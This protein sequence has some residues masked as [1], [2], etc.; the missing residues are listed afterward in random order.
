MAG[1]QGAH[2]RTPPPDE[3]RCTAL[4]VRGERCG[5]YR[6]RDLELC[7]RHSGIAD[8]AR[9]EQNALKSAE[10][11]MAERARENYLRDL[12]AIEDRQKDLL[13]PPARTPE[14]EA[15]RQV[16]ARK[17]LGPNHMPNRRLGWMQDADGFYFK[18]VVISQDELE[19]RDR[20]MRQTVDVDA[21]ERRDEEIRERDRQARAAW[22]RR[23]PEYARAR[24]FWGNPDVGVPPMPG[25]SSA[26]PS[27]EE[28]PWLY[29]PRVSKPTSY[30][31]TP[32]ADQTLWGV[33]IGPHLD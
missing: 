32:L 5:S 33:Q 13:T 24:I 31:P 29:D 8:E 22:S 3:R 2:F 6:A 4:N 17:D 27:R 16:W 25:W 7:A 12:K 10:Q 20:M 14:M 9:Q 1:N 30:E 11:R 28:Y 23:Y 19:Q 26:V 15:R 18:W 21:A